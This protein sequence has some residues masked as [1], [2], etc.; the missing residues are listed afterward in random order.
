MIVGGEMKYRVTRACV[1]R[2]S[3]VQKYSHNTLINPLFLGLYSHIV[4]MCIGYYINMINNKVRLIDLAVGD[5]FWYQTTWNVVHGIKAHGSF[6][7][8]YDDDGYRMLEEMST[9]LM[10]YR[11]VD[12][13]TEE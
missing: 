11:E 12:Q 13:T 8:I 6:A 4:L 9:A 1:C 3:L 10:V 5:L 2:P 7:Y